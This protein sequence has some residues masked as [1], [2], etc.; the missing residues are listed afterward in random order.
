MGEWD[1][2]PPG[3][4]EPWLELRGARL[5]VVGDELIRRNSRGGIVLRLRLADIEE[6]TTRTGLD[7]MAGVCFAAGVGLA[8][9]GCFVSES[10]WLTVVLYI[11]AGAALLLATIGAI[12]Q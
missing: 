5:A 4:A 7:P 12:R 11:L 2:E 1:G 3:G 6:V 9:L 8:L 10:T